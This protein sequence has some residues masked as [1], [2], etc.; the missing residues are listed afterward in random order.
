MSSLEPPDASIM[1]ELL[2]ALPIW[3]VP[4]AVASS[5]A[6]LTMMLLPVLR[7]SAWLLLLASIVGNYFIGAMLRRH[8]SRVT[9]GLGVA[10]NLAVLG[11]FKYAN[12]FLDNLDRLRIKMIHRLGGSRAQ[13]QESG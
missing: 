4:P 6:A 12:F 2:S 11:Y 5:V 13:S 8:R 1:P 10:A 3:S 9:L 7:T